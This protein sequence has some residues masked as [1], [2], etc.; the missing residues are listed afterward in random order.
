LIA[1]PL[2]IKSVKLSYFAA[3]TKNVNPS[4]AIRPAVATNTE[5]HLLIEAGPAGISFVV[6][7]NDH[8]FSALVWY[9]FP[10]DMSNDTI[11]AEMN[12]II[13]NEPLLK[14]QFKKTDIV[15]AF[16]EVMLVPHEWMKAEITGEMLELVHGDL[17]RGEVKTD[18]MFKQNLHTVYR[19][20]VAV[21]AV[22]A[23]HFLFANQTHQ[24]AVLPDLF[25]NE[26]NQLY[27]IFYNNRLTAML[28]KENKLQ[29]I[30]SFSYQNPED[31]AFHLLDLCR[32]FDV[33]PNDVVVRYSGM[34]D[35]RSSLFTELYRY[36]LTIRPTELPEEISIDEAIKKYP[37]HFFSHLFATALCV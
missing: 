5:T 13:Q 3:Q 7:D 9:A 17:N 8:F 24:Y 37:P 25:L 14:R 6:E 35:E 18:F 20:P 23:K 27:V 22:F 2:S 32:A 26:P 28:H 29:A 12:E 36:F 15:W 16:P 11:A 4:F 33:A 1:V 31:A 21:A 34:I 19:V 10:S 30:Q